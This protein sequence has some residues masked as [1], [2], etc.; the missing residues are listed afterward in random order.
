MMWRTLSRIFRFGKTRNH[1]M[2]EVDPNRLCLPPEIIDEIIDYLH[3]DKK[4]L[5]LLSRVSKRALVRSRRYL[6]HTVHIIEDDRRLEGF[7]YLVSSPWTSFTFAVKRI[8]LEGLFKPRYRWRPVRKI[9][10]VAANLCNV[11]TVCISSTHNRCSSWALIPIDLRKIL[12]QMKMQDL[13]LDSLELYH[14]GSLKNFLDMFPPSIKSLSLSNLRFGKILFPSNAA[15]VLRHVKFTLLDTSSLVLFKGAFDVMVSNQISI[16]VDAFHLRLFA[17]SVE[18]DIV[19]FKAKILKHVGPS[20]KHLL[21]DL[22]GK[23]FD[24]TEPMKF[25]D[26]ID[27]S[28]CFNIRV[29]SIGTV[30]LRPGTTGTSPSPDLLPNMWKILGAL[31]R[32][33]ALEQIWIAFDPNMSLL[34]DQLKELGAFQWTNLISRLR[35]IFPNL[36]K[37]KILIGG[38]DPEELPHQALC[39]RSVVKALEEEE[40][41]VDICM[42]N[43]SPIV[44]AWSDSVGQYFKVLSSHGEIC[45]RIYR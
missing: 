14:H 21:I 38:N 22:G 15:S 37:V 34:E 23:Y 13:R 9:S 12:F 43:G 39:Q 24:P 7:L 33:H 27:F 16:T 18:R 6:F 41:L 11:A 36:E 42:I 26:V 5:L 31:P 3:D 44:S 32:P 35:R 28:T 25:Y 40:G 30:A 2:V 1:N 8:L 20:I 10:R 19:V 17:S 29:L 45:T 4:A